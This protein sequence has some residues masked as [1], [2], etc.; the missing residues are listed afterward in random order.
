MNLYLNPNISTLLESIAEDAVELG[1]DVRF[2]GGCAAHAR[3]K[4]NALARSLDNLVSNALKY[5]GSAELSC[6]RV[7]RD[8]LIRVADRGPGLLADQIELAFQPFR[9]LATAPVG[10]APGGSGIG[11]TIARAQVATFGAELTLANRDGG[12]LEATI[13]IPGDNVT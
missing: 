3:V 13:R 10:C 8:L 12:G 4:P 2:T 5:A 7:R 1:A 11:L 9:R 6:V